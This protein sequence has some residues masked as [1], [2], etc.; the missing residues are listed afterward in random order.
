MGKLS[1]AGK[2]LNALF[3]AMKEDLNDQQSTEPSK[4]FAIERQVLRMRKR[5]KLDNGELRLKAVA[6]FI[7]TNLVVGRGGVTLDGDLVTEARYFILRV[8]ENF[9]TSKDDRCV[10]ETLDYPLLYSMWK[11]GPGTSYGVDGTHCVDKLEKPMSCTIQCKPLV[12]QLRRSNPYFRR[13]DAH[14]GNDGTVVVRGSRLSTVLKNETTHRTICIEPSGNMALQLAAGLYLEGALRYI[15]LD[16]RDQQPK[17]K[18][19]ALGGSITGGIATIDLKSASDMYSPELVRL[20]FPERWFALLMAIRSPETEHGDG[21]WLKLNMI[22]TMGNGF[23]FPLMTLINVALIYA[24]RRLNRNGKPNRIDWLN[25]CVFGD[26]IIVPVDEYEE[27]TRTLS[28]A[29][30]VV[31]HDKSFASGP[32]RESCGGDY[33]LGYDVTPVYPQSVATESEIYSVINQLYEWG[34]RHNIILTRSILTLKEMMPVGVK[35]KF[36]PEWHNP[37]EGFL[38]PR[39]SRRYKFLKVVQNRRA[40]KSGFFDM[41]LAC[42]GYITETLTSYY[43]GPRPANFKLDVFY[44]P[45]QFKT[46]YKVKSA[47]L[48]EGYLDGWAAEKRSS[49]A[50][51]FIGSYSFLLE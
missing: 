35:V 2:R 33:H 9:T 48:P 16:I 42:G 25:T 23:T 8:L 11:F 47:R 29:G 30:L 45:R 7:S 31:N 36:I 44:V 17:N 15:G 41:M 46:R 12:L 4:A 18:A 24:Y 6:D 20:L 22:S 5:A 38:T 50:S 51:N 1:V 37:D 19:L 28:C 27:C 21:E 32:F 43:Q 13:Y 39:V 26:D 40:Y 10:Q 49:E 34:S 3:A 14:N